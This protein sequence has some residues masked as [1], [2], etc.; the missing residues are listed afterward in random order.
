MR[1][2]RGNVDT[3]L[4]KLHAGE[5]DAVVL[6][7]AGLRRLGLEANITE[8]LPT[9]LLLPAVG[10]GA[11]GLETRADDRAAREAIAALDHADTHHGVLAERALLARLRGGCLAPVAAWGRIEAGR[12]RL[13]GRVLSVDGSKRLEA[14]SSAELSGV[15]AAARP[16]TSAAR[17][18][19]NCWGKVRRN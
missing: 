1:D 17:W 12:L 10:Q 3:R 16:K 19:T 13:T 18:P 9:S 4:R 5:F 8:V 14:S 6:A 15:K 11:L 2:I 7:E